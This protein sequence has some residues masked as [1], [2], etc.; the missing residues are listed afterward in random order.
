METERWETD[1]REMETANQHTNIRIAPIG[2]SSTPQ[3][4]AFTVFR[5]IPNEHGPN[6]AARQQ[7]VLN[8]CPWVWITILCKWPNETDGAVDYTAR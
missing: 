6:I 2:S 8:M 7:V 1:E 3:W 5:I 4:I